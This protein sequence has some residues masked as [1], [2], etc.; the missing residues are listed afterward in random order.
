MAFCR[1]DLRVAGDSK[2]SPPHIL[3]S[4]GNNM[5]AGIN[6]NYTE[7]ARDAALRGTTTL[8]FDIRRL[9]DSPPLLRWDL[10]PSRVRRPGFLDRRRRNLERTKNVLRRIFACS[11]VPVEQSLLAEL[12]AQLVARDIDLVA[13]GCL[14]RGGHELYVEA[15]ESVRSE[16]DASGRFRLEGIN[17][18]DHIFSPLWGQE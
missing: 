17:R 6:R 15:I 11:A 8:R 14:E 18:T 4:G 10:D 3:V 13:G 2:P 7:W 9:G 16:L 12:L 5:R 1:D